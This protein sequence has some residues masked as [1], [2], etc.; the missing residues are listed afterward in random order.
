MIS[1]VACSGPK[2]E[3]VTLE[4]ETCEGDDVMLIADFYYPANA[5]IIV[6][7]DDEYP[8]WKVFQNEKEN[9][10]LS[11]SLFED[12]TFDYHQEADKK[13]E[14]TYSEF[15]VGPYDAYGYESFGGYYI[16]IHLEEVS[17]NTDRYI[18]ADIGRIRF[19]ED[20]PK[21][22]DAYH[23]NKVAKSIVESLVYNGVVSIE[24]V[25]AE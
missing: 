11:I 2:G 10:E 1:L 9:Y 6:I 13:N 19:G 20:E 15:K 7:G 8:N 17:E 22:I 5:G 21:G 4:S 25:S 16:Y 3:K 14:A 18:V 24:S 12:T 23:E